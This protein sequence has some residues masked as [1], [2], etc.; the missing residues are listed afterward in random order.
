VREQWK[1]DPWFAGLLGLI[2]LGA[3]MSLLTASWFNLCANLVVLWGLLTYNYWVYIIVVVLVG[4]SVLQGGLVLITAQTS[5][6][7]LFGLAVQTFI[8]VVLL[9]RYDHYT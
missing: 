2:A 4:L 7:G 9:R 5:L 8:F 6:A 3:V 1:E